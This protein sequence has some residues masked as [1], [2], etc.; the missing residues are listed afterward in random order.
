MSMSDD[1]EKLHRLHTEGALTDEE[2]TLAKKRVIEGEPVARVVRET[3]RET[4]REAGRAQ[5]VLNEFRLS[6]KQRWIAGVC[7]GLA[8]LTQIPAWSWRI[9]FVLT[10][11]L[12]GLGVIMYL[13]LWIFVPRASLSAPVIQTA[14]AAPQSPPPVPP[15]E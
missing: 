6:N 5:S 3:F 2:F 8:E 10:A 14:A 15:Q 11:L 9:L 12:H 13:L 7:G 4:V 1:L